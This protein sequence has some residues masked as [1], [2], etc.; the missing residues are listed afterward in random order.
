MKLTIIREDGFISID[1][2]Y[3]HIDLT[4]MPEDFHALQWSE[5]SG[6]IERQG[7]MNQPIDSL[8]DF[9][10]WIIRGQEAIAAKVQQELAEENSVP[11]R[12]T[13]FQAQAALQLAGLLDTAIDYI[14]QPSTPVLTKIAWDKALHFER[15]S[16]MV[17]TIGAELGL[18]EQ[19]LDNLFIQAETIK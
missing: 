3:A 6:E 17:T 12:V 16:P 13:A 19:E 18:T 4:D 8:E 1:G 2:Q 15:H 9:Q 5:Q 14:N 10:P 7:L 11:K